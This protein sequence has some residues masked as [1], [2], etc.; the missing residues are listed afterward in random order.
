M[1][2]GNTAKSAIKTTQLNDL[3]QSLAAIQGG[4]HQ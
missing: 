3:N 1:Y 2:D 4:T